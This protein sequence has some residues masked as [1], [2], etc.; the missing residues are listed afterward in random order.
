MIPKRFWNEIGI[1]VET[2]LFK[3]GPIGVYMIGF[4]GDV[5]TISINRIRKVDPISFETEPF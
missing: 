5:W 4:Y 1:G 3:I 2:L